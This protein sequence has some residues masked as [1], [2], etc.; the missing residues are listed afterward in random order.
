MLCGKLKKSL[1]G[2]RCAP[3]RWSDTRDECINTLEIMDDEYGPMI[4]SQC[5]T[6]KN[7]WKVVSSQHKEVLGFFMVYVDD[8]I[9]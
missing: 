9:M 4:C 7:V 2:L 6:F 8:V 5:P 1:Y 3:K